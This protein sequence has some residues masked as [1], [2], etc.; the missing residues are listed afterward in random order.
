VCLVHCCCNVCLL[1]HSDIRSLEDDCFHC[2]TVSVAMP[3]LPQP[4]DEN[5]LTTLTLRN[6]HA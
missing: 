5:I 3:C 2:C 4:R 1:I 6:S